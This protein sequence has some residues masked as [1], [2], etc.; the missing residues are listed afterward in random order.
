M[1]VSVLLLGRVMVS[2]AH[3]GWPSGN[4]SL[5]VLVIV[6]GPY[7][8]VMVVTLA[9]NSGDMVATR[10]VTRPAISARYLPQW[11]P[12]LR[13][14]R[15]I[16][17]ELIS[18]EGLVTIS[19]GARSYGGGHDSLNFDFGHCDHAGQCLAHCPSAGNAGC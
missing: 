2:C 9:G 7:V 12:P 3:D 8:L 10:L 18:T 14:K 17:V 15:D 1:S 19:P 16:M 6:L 4:G 5:V 13:L 11:V